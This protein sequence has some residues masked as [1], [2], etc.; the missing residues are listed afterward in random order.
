M[1]TTAIEA[2]QVYDQKAK[3]LYGEF[4]KLNLEEKSGE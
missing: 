2:A 3:D 1:F 4:A